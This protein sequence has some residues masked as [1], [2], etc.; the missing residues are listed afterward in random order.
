M[1]S[2]ELVTLIEKFI[3]KHGDVKVDTEYYCEECKDM[4]EGNGVKPIL[5][6]DHTMK[7]EIIELGSGYED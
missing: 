7:I 1:L 6:S 4:H 2:S 5:T 3:Q